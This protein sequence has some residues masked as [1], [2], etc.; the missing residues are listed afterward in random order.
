VELVLPETGVCS[1]P[2]AAD[3]AA[4][5]AGC[6]AADVKAKAPGRPGCC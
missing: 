4:A 2:P 5:A 1:G 6:C 3:P